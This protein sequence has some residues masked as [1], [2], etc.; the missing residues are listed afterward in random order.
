MP[1]D[2]TL[3]YRPWIGSISGSISGIFRSICGCRSFH[4]VHRSMKRSRILH[5]RERIAFENKT[6]DAH[7]HGE[8]IVIERLGIFA[9]KSRPDFMTR[10]KSKDAPD[11]EP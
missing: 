9:E 8:E 3:R 4:D 2:A 7:E 1:S 5:G 11:V 6:W 10:A